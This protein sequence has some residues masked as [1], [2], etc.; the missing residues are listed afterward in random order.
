MANISFTTP[1]ALCFMALMCI[2]I[3]FLPRRFA[4]IPI[5]LTG[6][7][8]T[9]GQRIVIATLD[10]TMLRILIL[11]GFARVIIKK[12]FFLLKLTKIDRTFIWWVI[13]SIVAYTLV[14]KTT[15]A[16]INRMGMSLDAI[17][18]YFLFRIFIQDFHEIITLFKVLAIILLP[19]SIAMLIE[20]AT[21]RNL[22]SILGGVPEVT[23]IRD[24]K[25]RCQGAF[26]HPILAG[27]FGAT[28]LPLF[29]S[30]WFNNLRFLTVIG[31]I[32]ATIIA[33]TA[34]SSGPLIAYVFGIIGLY[35]WLLRSHMRAIRWGIVGGALSL[36]IIMKAPVWYLS[37]RVSNIIGGTGWY[38]AALID[39]AIKHFNEWWLIGTNFT[40]HW[41]PECFLIS[42]G[43]IDITNQYISEA[44]NGGLLKMILFIYIIVLCFRNLGRLIREIEEQCFTMK[45]TLWAMGA[46]L[47]AHAV[48]FF[49]VS[50]FDQILIF[51]YLILSI[52]STASTFLKEPKHIRGNP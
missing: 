9:L 38:R 44:V 42:P 16:F 7:Y 40:A 46:S 17:G 29:A 30:L 22:F 41:L 50:Y 51:W 27:T 20:N 10:F 35:L 6:C 49:S 37:D 18:C 47:F 48:S 25:M 28:T 3:F 1:S 45:I 21:G 36:H 39:A 31:A 52:I 2:L 23:L 15:G 14:Y 4:F 19:L 13:V 11:F 33:F 32:S 8:I 34:S 12:E 26:R 24:G 5:L 43:K